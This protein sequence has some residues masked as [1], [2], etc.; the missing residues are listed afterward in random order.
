MNFNSPFFVTQVECPVCGKINDFENIR[1]GAYTETE[2]DT[3]FC[4]KGIIWV[5]PE[6]QKANPLLYFMAT[7]PHCFYTHEFNNSFKEWKKNRFFSTRRLSSIRKKHLQEL[8]QPE[9]AINRFG[10]ALDPEGHPFESAVIKLLLGIHDETIIE[11]FNPWDVGRYY[12]RIAWLY[13]ENGQQK[14]T[15]RNLNEFSLTRLERTMNR[16]RSHYGNEEDE[17]HHLA[18]AVETCFPPPAG[19]AEQDRQRRGLRT[20][21]TQ[22]VNKI[23][24]DISS[25]RE[26]L[27]ELAE[28]LAESKNLM[29]VSESG[30]I[31]I[32]AEAGE[33]SISG[34]T[35]REGKNQPIFGTFLASIKKIWPELPLG[36]IEAMKFALGYYK[37][38]HQQ[39]TEIEQENQ[40]IQAA[41]LIAELSRRVG[42]YGEAESYF[43]EAKRIGQDFIRRNQDDLNKIALAQKIVELAESQKKLNLVKAKPQV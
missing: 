29:V 32:A 31:E 4:P 33:N 30:N 36:E 9:S 21:I 39:T 13:R 38:S 23:K 16:L 26:N 34:E 35:F 18:M 1:A 40:K 37:Q 10:E 7:C 14:D 24:G 19:I 27:D 8:G 6:Y 3:D 22:A 11:E 28:I 17:I 20:E 41:Y 43:D 25:L 12:L 42:N 5:N 15:A 2:R